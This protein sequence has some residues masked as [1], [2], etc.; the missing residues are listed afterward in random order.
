[1]TAE[2]FLLNPRNASGGL[3]HEAAP[4]PFGQG[5]LLTFL[6]IFALFGI[7]FFGFVGR[8]WYYAWVLTMDGREVVGTVERLT[9]H[10]DSEGGATYRVEFRFEVAGSQEGTQEHRGG[11]QIGASDFRRLQEGGPVT[12]RYAQGRPWIARSEGAPWQR[13][14][15]LLGLTA[16]LCVWEAVPVGLLYLGIR[17]RRRRRERS[18]AGVLLPG[19]VERVKWHTD[20]D[21]DGILEIEYSFTAPDGQTLRGKGSETRNDLRTAGRMPEVGDGVRVLYASA[22]NHVVL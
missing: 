19:R 15:P 12:I 6:T 4:G 14:L 1:M 17:E 16:F 5:C 3:P 20:S 13:P 7:P 8:E 11:N 2:P 10:E 18:E 9:E 21:G 22:K